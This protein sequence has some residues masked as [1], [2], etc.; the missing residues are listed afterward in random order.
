MQQSN[1]YHKVNKIYLLTNKK[2]KLEQRHKQARLE[3]RRGVNAKIF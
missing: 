1:N 2:N 3:G